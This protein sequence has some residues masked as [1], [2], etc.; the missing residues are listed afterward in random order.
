ME[1]TINYVAVL[2]AAI[3]NMALG[4]VWYSP[5]LFG[6]TWIALTGLTP[7]KMQEAKARGMGK[8]YAVAFLA[9]LVLACVLAHAVELWA[10]S[11]V[12]QA[13]TLAFWAWLGFIAPVLLG[14]VLWEGKPVRLY[15]LNVSYYLVALVLM[16]A[17]LVQWR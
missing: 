13:L 8:T 10:A 16:A 3:A 9:S 17:I 2:V 4:S 15:V 12:G 7:E 11:T 5:V 1:F 6:K 14:S